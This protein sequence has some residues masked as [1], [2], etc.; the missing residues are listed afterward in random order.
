MQ[1]SLPFLKNPFSGSHGRGS[2]QS[3]VLAVLQRVLIFC[4][5]IPLKQWID[6]RADR[7]LGGNAAAR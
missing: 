7:R 3:V 1:R 6:V 2:R 4:V 5:V